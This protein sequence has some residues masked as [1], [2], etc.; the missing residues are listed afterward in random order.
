MFLWGCVAAGYDV[1]DGLHAAHA[2]VGVGVGVVVVEPAAS[3]TGT[4]YTG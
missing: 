2:V 1:L 4:E 3:G